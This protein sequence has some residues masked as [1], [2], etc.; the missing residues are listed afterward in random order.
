MKTTLVVSRSCQPEAD[1]LAQAAAKINWNCKAIDQVRELPTGPLALYGETYVAV[2]A[3]RR[4]DLALIEPWPDL[5]AQRHSS[6]EN[7]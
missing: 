7:R 1:R 4:F 5:P 3:A 2:E 6:V